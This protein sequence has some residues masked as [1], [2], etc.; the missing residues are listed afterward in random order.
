MKKKDE[1]IKISATGNDFIL[2]DNREGAWDGRRDALVFSRLCQRRIAIGADG[3]ILLEK[4][5]VADFRYV[6]INSDGSNAEMCGNG[7]RAIS[8]FAYQLGIFSHQTSFEINGNIYRATID[9]FHV[10][11]EFV[12][13]GEHNLELAIIEEP[14]IQSGG[15]IDTGVPHFVVF[16]DDVAQTD[17]DGLGCKYRRHPVFNRGTN[18]DFVQVI[19]ENHLKVR[20]FERGVEAETLA[21][22]TGAVA[23]AIIS[24][25]KKSTHSP[26]ILTFPGGDLQV[27]FSA[28]F[29]HITLAGLVRPVYRGVLEESFYA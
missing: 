29:R 13:P 10:I 17:V 16:V 11:T 28:D 5:K 20:T 23:S 26:T 4:S 3:V 12:A 14:E 24:H 21:C 2:F 19:D 25:F 22:G 18:V 8:W 1:F 6:H 27:T 7:S 15:S 9:G